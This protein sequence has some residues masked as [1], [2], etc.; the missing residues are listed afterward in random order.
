MTIK[1][2]TKLEPRVQ[3]ALLI[4]H[5]MEVLADAD[6]LLSSVQTRKNHVVLR[7][8]LDF[9]QEMF[10]ATIDSVTRLKDDVDRVMKELDR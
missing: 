8:E 9:L 4:G 10:G 1:D 7:D 3:A 2:N 6:V 5:L